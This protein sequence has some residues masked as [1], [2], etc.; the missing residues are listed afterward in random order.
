MNS[1]SKAEPSGN[2]NSRLRQWQAE[3]EERKKVP[4]LASKISDASDKI[5]AGTLTRQPVQKSSSGY[6]S[7]AIEKSAIS[8]LGKVVTKLNIAQ[9]AAKSSSQESKIVPPKDPV[10]KASGVLKNQSV[11]GT[12]RSSLPSHRTSHEPDMKAM[13]NTNA[14]ANTEASSD[15][16][17]SNKNNIL[18][19]RSQSEVSDTSCAIDV[20]HDVDY[21]R[22][23]LKQLIL[24]KFTLLDEEAE[25]RVKVESDLINAWKVGQTYYINVIYGIYA[26]FYHTSVR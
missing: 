24:V 13:G 4:K 21:L 9:H 25:E 7:H 3:K 22:T 14:A 23:L 11:P 10:N 18:T 1:I 20:M 5:P 8:S 26:C 15:F 19:H 17:N 16:E 6:H 12:A 2:L